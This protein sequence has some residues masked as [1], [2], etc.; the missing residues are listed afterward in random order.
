MALP[1]Q[2]DP[3]S[4]LVAHAR[5]QRKRAKED[6]C[7]GRW[8]TLEE[9]KALVARIRAFDELDAKVQ[10]ISGPQFHYDGEDV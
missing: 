9:A 3:Y 8:T 10:E 7:A 1:R 2:L 5:D 6:L 4:R